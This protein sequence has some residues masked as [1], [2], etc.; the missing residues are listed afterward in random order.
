MQLV[1]ATVTV[2]CLATML[3]ACALRGGGENDGSTE[4]RLRSLEENFLQF[5]E[6]QRESEDRAREMERRVEER[7]ASMEEKLDGTTPKAPGTAE[8]ADG[9]AMS[10]PDAPSESV[11]PPA[12]SVAVTEPPVVSGPESGEP[13]PWDE[14]PK[15]GTAQHGG[16]KPDT[17]KNAATPGVPGGAQGLYDA[18]LKATL[19]DKPAE[20]RKLWEDFLTRY[21]ASKLAPN[22]D[23]WLGET[24][25]AEKNYPL[26]ILSFQKVRQDYPKHEKAAAALLKIGMSYRMSGDR[27]NALLYLRALLDQYPKSEPAPIAR[28]QI[29]ELGG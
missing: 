19:A 12:G 21:P 28:Q 5:K 6:Q 13:R 26:A 1:K 24:Y 17:A 9:A 14:M 11:L 8:T 4:W 2:L 25:Y 27:D 20:G 3:S 18:A 16:M 15:P 23:Y 29:R 7:L 22:A 10:Y